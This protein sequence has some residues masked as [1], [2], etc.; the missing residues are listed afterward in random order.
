MSFTWDRIHKWEENFE[1][2]I[3]DSVEE[4]I[5][6]FYDVKMVD[7]LS[8]EQIREVKAFQEDYNEY[9]VM[10][11][12]LKQVVEMWIAAHSENEMFDLEDKPDD[13]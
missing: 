6:E 10:Q 13:D 1:R 8:E 4:Y 12:G 2:E 9:S 11:Y 3:T 7:F 5:C